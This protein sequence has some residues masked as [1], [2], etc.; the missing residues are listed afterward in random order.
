MTKLFY[1]RRI[2]FFFTILLL[3]SCTAHQSP[4]VQEKSLADAVVYELNVRQSTPEGTF[5]ALNDRLETLKDLGVDIVWVMP[6]YPIGVL[7]RKG[8][9]G[10]YYAICDYC[11]INPEFGTLEDFDRFVE[12]AHSLG[13]KVILD[14]VGNHTSPDHPW[15][16][17]KPADW[18]VRDENGKTIVEYDWTDIAKLNLENEDVIAAEAEAMLF[19][20]GR[21]VDG[22]RCDVAYQ[23]PRHFWETVIP[24]LKNAY[25]GDLYMLAEGEEPWL[26][27]VGFNTTY[28][29][30]LHALTKDIASGRA[31]VKELVEY[32]NWDRESF[33]ADHYR[34]AFTSN[35]DE[36]SWAG[37]EFELFGEA[38]GAITLLEWTLPNSQP[39]IYTG[40]EIGYNHRFQFFEKDHITSYQTNKYTNLYRDL[41]KMRRD[42]PSL[43]PGEG[44]FEIISTENNTIV[45]E[46]RNEGDVARVSVQ[47]EAP[48]AYSIEFPEDIVARIEPPCW[49][50][51]MDNNEVQLLVK[52]EGISE[53]SVAIEGGKGVNIVKVNKAQSPNYLFVDL[54]ISDAAEAGQ[55]QLVFTK[56]EKIIRKQY[57]IFAR[58]E[59][60]AQR[61]SFTTADAV[62]LIMPDRYVNGDKTNDNIYGMVEKADPKEF[63][64]RFGGDLQ[65]IINQLDYIAELGFTAIWN[66]PVQEDNL[67]E[68][69]YHGYACS[70]YY[71]IDPRFGGN[72][73]YR[74][75]VSEAHKRGIKV[76]MDVVTNHSS[77]AY[78]WME[79]LPF[80]DW[81]HQWP[82]YTKSNCSFTI[83]HDPYASK[84]D[85]ENMQNGWFDTTMVDM[86]LDNPFTLRYLTQ[87]YTWW[88]EWA[89]LDGFRVDTVPYNEPQPFGEFCAA[90]RRE[91]PNFNIVG[92]V[93]SQIPHQ[94]AYWQDDNPN[95]DGFDSNMPSVMDFPLQS[96]IC[97]AINE[98]TQNWDTGLQ[99]VL[100]AIAND[101]CYRDLKNMM[102]F[103]GNHDMD[104]IG[105]V[106]E[107]DPAK[108]KLVMALIATV[109]GFPQIFAGDEVILRASDRSQGH[110]G[111]R[112]PFDFN[113]VK[114]PAKVEVHDY[115]CKL[116]N[117]R[118]GSD[119]IHNG[120]TLHFIN[121]DNIY[122]FFRYTDKER[123]FVYANNNATPRT[124]NMGDYSEFTLKGEGRDV[125]T[126]ETINPDGYV[127]PAKTA[128][129]IEYKD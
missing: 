5:A 32:I 109:R 12:K 67:P 108:M 125:I 86:N 115:V 1:M 94:I 58:R 129:I 110:G 19:W 29:W 35:H 15:V 41:I 48:W 21:G 78:W 62:Y 111:L 127:V 116:F 92:E 7:E 87:M 123:V 53:Y 26:A 91:Y 71:E 93:W 20:I 113:W 37:T 84:K 31:G 4:V 85:I 56:G 66:T 2:A 128:L 47:L 75:F 27:E 119:A 100:D 10:S 99:R 79:D 117:W 38:L 106:V 60:S 18:Y 49:W 76:I 72:Y 51:G 81:V 59:G 80:E 50:V 30:R 73:K 28:T 23:M 42:H 88:V 6:P 77:S 46:R 52:G 16:T 102:V 118:K 97:R 61:K 17:E 126:G 43:R 9:L 11:N 82:S 69:S 114:D 24:Q 22:F 44:T 40:Q 121:R 36:N 90:I 33:P 39:L 95:P 8:S 64:G 96:A 101:N 68:S 89:D 107:G 55:Y 103:C 34:L 13:L 57:D 14:W 98:D 65:G 45:Y 3:A 104:H 105:D 54:V 124:I 112:N 74:E 120:E 70:N 25:K 63:Y 83:H 122:A